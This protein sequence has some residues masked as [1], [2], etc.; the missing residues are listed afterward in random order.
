MKAC[1]DQ[2]CTRKGQLLELTDFA[3]N[4]SRDDGRNLYCLICSARRTHEYRTRLRAKKA[5]QKAL[6]ERKPMVIAP[7][8]NPRMKVFEA[9]QL[10]ARTRKQIKQF[11]QLHWDQVTDSL[12]ELCFDSR[13]VKIKRVGEEAVFEIAA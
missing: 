13:T 9:I 1:K 6:L 2:L 3:L 12:A 10:G 5:A 4:R 8:Q 11:T 7:K